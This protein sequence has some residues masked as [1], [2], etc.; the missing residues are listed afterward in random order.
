MISYII[1]EVIDILIL[2]GVLVA[3]WRIINMIPPDEPG[4][5][6]SIGEKVKHL[7]LIVSGLGIWFLL[8]TLAD[9]INY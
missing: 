1:N 2:L 4:C 9:S 3:S 7:V 8:P 5:Q 6:Y